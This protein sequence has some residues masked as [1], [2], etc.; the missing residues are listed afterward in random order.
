MIEGSYYDI[1]Q[2]I[3]AIG[4]K[5]SRKSKP[6]LASELTKL[7]RQQFMSNLF[8][9]QTDRDTAVHPDMIVVGGFYDCY[10]D[11]QDLP[12]I[13]ISLT[14][15]PDQEIYFTNL[16]DWEQLAFDIAEAVGHEMVHREQ[17]HQSRTGRKYVSQD[18]DPRRR[19]E[20]EYLGHDTEIEAYGFSIAFESWHRAIPVEAS[21]MFVIYSDVFDQDDKVLL[22]LQK[23][24][25]KYLKHLEASSCKTKKS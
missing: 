18:P 13:T 14:Y 10:D 7:I 9:A 2:R 22:K 5:H 3:C 21:P 17:H 19:D 20:Q 15:N 23:Y 4:E 24:I 11:S 16:V 1:Y 6:L 12:C 25:S 8:R